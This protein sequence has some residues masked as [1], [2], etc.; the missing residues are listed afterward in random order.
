V[1]L[2]LLVAAAIVLFAVLGAI[3]GALRQLL[4]LAAAAVGYAAARFLAPP[5]A[6]GLGR[7][8]PGPVARA[9]AALVL[10][11]AAFVLATLAGKLLLR[12]RAQGGLPRPG[13]RALGAFLGAAKA[14]LVLWVVLSAAAIVDRPF[15]P[16][17]LRLDPRQ[18]DFASLSREHNLLERWEGPTGSTLRGLLRV[19]KDP[20]RAAQL[21]A[22]ADARMLLEDPR[23][24]M[25]VGEARGGKDPG[26]LVGSPAALR[27]LSDPAFLE[28]LGRAQRRFDLTNAGR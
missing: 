25:L 19:A 22:D 14:S 10:F 11:F 15:G 17:W 5:V 12:S 21:L 8:L 13:D 9:T 2:D 26:A 27:L 7:S 18:S 20:D 24:Q 1:L 16:S 6:A 23:V 28:R 3:S 4:T